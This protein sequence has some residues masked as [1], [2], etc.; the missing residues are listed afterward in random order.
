MAM[1]LPNKINCFFSLSSL[2]CNPH[3]HSILTLTSHLAS[4]KGKFKQEVIEQGTNGVLLFKDGGEFESIW[5]Q[6]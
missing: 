5:K 6:H 4:G 3:P 1:M 2:Y